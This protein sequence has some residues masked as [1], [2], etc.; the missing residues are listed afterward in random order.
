MI[1]VIQKV[2]EARVDVENQTV[3]RIGTGLM[4]LLG[5]EDSDGNED[6][7]WL[8]RKIVNMRIFDDEDGVMNNSL[9]D[10]DGDILLVSQFTLHASTKK[11]NRP[12]YIKAAK[13]D[14]AIP[15][16][17]KF[18]ATLEADLGKGIQTGEFGAMMQVSL[19]NDG[20]VTIIIDTKDKK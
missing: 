5:I 12:S 2:S 8:S 1:A 20:P 16:Y 6:I 4:V 11:G 9:L 15:M 14:V 7:E 13:P 3:G 17:Q 19:C 10:V 18:I